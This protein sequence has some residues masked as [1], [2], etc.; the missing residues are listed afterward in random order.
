MEIVLMRSNRHLLLSA[1]LVALTLLLGPLT[2]SRVHAAITYCR[3]DPVATLSHGA[4][5]T[6]YADVYDT[7]SDLQ[8]A[9]FVL[10]VPTGVSVTG[11]TYD[12]IFGSFESLSWVADQNTGRYKV[13]TL[14]TTGASG[15][16]VV[17]TVAVSGMTCQLPS[18]STQGQSGK[19]LWTAFNC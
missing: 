14:V 17:A 7:A 19:D 13:D 6:M 11:V 18:K 5:I 15:I 4:Q 16:K 9:D 12:P 2:S 3:T 1:L 10:H 8:H